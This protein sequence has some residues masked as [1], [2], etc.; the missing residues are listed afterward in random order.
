MKARQ[1]RVVKKWKKHIYCNYLILKL[2]LYKKDKQMKAR[3]YEQRWLKFYNIN[4][5][6]NKSKFKHL[7]IFYVQYLY[8]KITELK[9]NN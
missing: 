5:S 2:Y 9:Q 7:Y 3:R 8:N 6:K 4:F 1:W